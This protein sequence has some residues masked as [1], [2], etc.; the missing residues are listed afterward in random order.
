MQLN[1]NHTTPGQFWTIAHELAHQFLGHIGQD[2]PLNIPDR[3]R[4]HHVQ[5]ELEAESV[6]YLVCPRNG[7]ESKSQTYLANYGAKSTTVD[8]L[9]LNQVIRAAAR[10]RPCLV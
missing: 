7:V 8:S 4:P 6:D 2:R 10:S 9:D 1:R 5:M 3:P